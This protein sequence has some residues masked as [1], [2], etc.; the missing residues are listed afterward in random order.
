MFTVI[1]MAG[2]NGRPGVKNANAYLWQKLEGERERG[3][4]IKSIFASHFMAFE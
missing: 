3:R 2:I 1:A 4:E